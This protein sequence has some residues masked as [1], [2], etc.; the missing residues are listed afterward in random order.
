MRP[1]KDFVIRISF[2]PFLYKDLT[3]CLFHIAPWYRIYFCR[4]IYSYFSVKRMFFVN[5]GPWKKTSS[6]DHHRNARQHPLHF[7][8]SSSSYGPWVVA[9]LSM[10]GAFHLWKG[11][12]HSLGVNCFSNASRLQ[13]HDFY[14]NAWSYITVCMMF[15]Q[16]YKNLTRHKCIVEY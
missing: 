3:K 8:W 14:F 16:W 11:S 4:W 5:I 9:T 1:D 12:P 13:K 7:S 10:E 2:S 15:L 6:L